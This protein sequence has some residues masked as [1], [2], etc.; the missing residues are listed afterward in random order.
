M[1]SRLKEWGIWVITL[2]GLLTLLIGLLSDKYW[3]A[4]INKILKM[5]DSLDSQ[6][7]HHTEAAKENQQKAQKELKTSEE[8]YKKYKEQLESAE[9][10]FED[11]VQAVN[12]SHDDLIK[13]ATKAQKDKNKEAMQEVHDELSSR[14]RNL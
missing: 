6:T 5:I 10:S 8:S 14:L 1:L 13:K 4:K 3:Q 11:D 9:E 2:G 7:K 12:A